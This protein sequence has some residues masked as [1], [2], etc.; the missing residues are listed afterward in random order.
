MSRIQ[1]QFTEPPGRRMTM[2]SQQMETAVRL[3]LNPVVLILEHGAYGMIRRKQ[4][5]NKFAD[6]GMTFGNPVFV[7]YAESYGAAVWCIDRT[8]ALTQRTRRP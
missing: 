5:A 3:R 7:N 6:W 1:Q 4:V 8:E 2:N